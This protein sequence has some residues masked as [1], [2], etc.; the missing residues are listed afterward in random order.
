MIMTK[1][2]RPYK[3]DPRIEKILFKIEKGENEIVKAQLSEIGIDTCD[4][5][6]RTALIWA[7]F[8]NNTDLLKWLIS[9]GANVN[10]KDKNGYT[11]LHFTGQE[12]N[13]ESAKILIEN[14]ADIELSDN[15]GNTPI[16]TAIFNSKGDYSLVKLLVSKG[17]NLDME[18]NH[19]MTPRQLAE[20]IA[21]F[22][23]N[24]LID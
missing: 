4:G 11:A 2:G 23:L 12:R 20:L 19:N 7:A 14:G 1:P 10:H 3:S 9:N 15:H 13:F 16:V 6:R 5:F 17:A 22:D 18:N 21:G 8:S 24:T